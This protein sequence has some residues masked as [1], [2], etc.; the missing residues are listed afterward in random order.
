MQN[1]D[2]S[3]DKVV[4]RV[5]LTIRATSS[6]AAQ[7]V[8]FHASLDRNLSIALGNTSKS[9]L[10]LAN[11]MLMDISPGFKPLEVGEAEIKSSA[12]WRTVSDTLDNCFEKVDMALDL[13]KSPNKS[14]FRVTELLEANESDVPEVTEKPQRNFMV[15]V[16]NSDTHPFKPKLTQKPHALKPL[17]ETIKLIAEDQ[18]NL[19]YSHPYEF[20]IMTQPFPDSQLVTQDPKKPIDWTFSEPIWIDDAMG[21]NEMVKELEQLSEIAVDL[22]HHDYRSYYGIT[23]LMQI[24]NREKDWLIDTLA[25]RDNLEILNRVFADPSIVKVFHGANMDIHWLQRDLGLYVVS[26]F[27][28]YHASKKL[29]FP[30]FSLAY[31]LETIAHFKT[32]KKYQLADWRIRPLTALM[33]QY[34]RADTHFLLYIFDIL[35][36]KLI[37]KGNLQD[38]LYESRRVACRRYEYSTFRKD[39]NEWPDEQFGLLKRMRLQYNLPNS[40]ATMLESL[41]AWRDHLAR[42]ADESPRYILSNQALINLCN[43]SFPIDSKKIMSA[44]GRCS[45][46]VRAEL[47][48]VSEIIQ[49]SM[50]NH[51]GSLEGHEII[52]PSHDIVNYA[53]ALDNYE[54]FNK[55]KKEPLAKRFQLVMSYSS[56]FSSVCAQDDLSFSIK[57]DT[58]KRE[59]LVSQFELENRRD[60]I[61]DAFRASIRENEEKNMNKLAVGKPDSLIDASNIDKTKTELQE[62]LPEI[63]SLSNKN[64]RTNRKML[65]KSSA[66]PIF[67]YNAPENTKVLGSITAEPKNKK[68]SFDPFSKAGSGGPRAAKRTKNA[69]VGKSGSFKNKRS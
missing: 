20:E 36:N 54:L 61:K 15:K 38:V 22:E 31:L 18:N 41:L 45:D 64:R 17:H 44:I 6:L 47:S 26:L 63:F 9:L 33:V 4:P 25:L 16:D 21:L 50:E 19:H 46:E 53:T 30:K 56:C 34:A 27:D 55:L 37:E 13:L 43:L 7:D 29:G 3:Y 65:T 66:E 42:V 5:I 69:P 23:C 48:S 58:N 14:D 67:D 59:I 8:K 11:A 10:S 12:T 57:F 40:R 35:K 2:S 68:R 51:D 24:S 62:K 39:F 49:K 32:S 1:H 28:T 60:V 52:S